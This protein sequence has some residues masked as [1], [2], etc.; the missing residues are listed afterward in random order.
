MLSKNFVK[1]HFDF[2]KELSGISD[3]PKRWKRCVASTEASLGELLAQPFIEKMFS[4]DAKIAADE[5]VAE[6][7]NAF[8]SL[9][10]KLKWMSPG[11][12]TK[13]LDKLSK[14]EYLVGYPD[15]WKK[16][17]F[18]VQANDYVGNVLGSWT[19][20][21]KREL[22]KIG[23]PVDR[24]LW[25]MTPQTVN[26]YYHPLHNH[27]VFPAGILQSPFFNA[28][29]HIPVNLGAIGMV[30]GH[31]LTHGFDDKG[32]QFDGAGNLSNWWAES[33]RT[34]FEKRGQ[35]MVDQFAKYESL[36]GHHLNG[37]LTLGENIADSGGV[38]LAFKA[39][40]AMTQKADVKK[41]ADGFTE[42]QQFFI[43][44]GQAWCNKYR[45]KEAKKRVL[46]DSHSPP[47]F[48]VNGTLSNLPEFKEAFECP[49]G[50]PMAPAQTC[51][52]W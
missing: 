21:T 26:A 33:D 41:V 44:T 24:S 7:S 48:R 42:D 43:S 12:K 15:V 11:T 49:A 36:P 22:N 29:A 10:N 34:E 13:A 9:V 19:Y 5:M 35:C 32:S 1:L 3:I 16:Y 28:K 31:E 25:Y 18:E 50:A 46:T 39:Y 51:E 52:I 45:E 4:G 37:E 8:K 14:M 6:V 2:K 30:V 47:R 38:K 27:M 23:K 20:E 17:D 40:K